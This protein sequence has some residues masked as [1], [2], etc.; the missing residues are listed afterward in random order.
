MAGRRLA[1]PQKK[2]AEEGRTIVFVDESG[3]YLLPMAVRTYA[4]RGQTPILRVPL[5][6]DHL[7]VIGAITARG[8]VL[9]QNQPHSYTA[10]D[11]VRFLLVCYS[12]RCREN[13]SSFGMALRFIAGRLSRNSWR[14]ERPSV[15]IWNACPACARPQCARRD[16][17]SAQTGELR[18]VCCRNLAE[19]A[20]E[21]Q[22]A[23]GRLRHRREVILACFAHAACPL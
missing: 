13:C 16:L 2:A 14:E 20:Q 5:T 9:F 17:E 21:V 6:H 7:S 1:S 22:W 12:A 15:S 4:P 11:V 23:K 10:A 8:Q 19:L 18:N 3:F